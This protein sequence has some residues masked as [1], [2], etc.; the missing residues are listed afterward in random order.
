M[1]PVHVRVTH[2]SNV[3]ARLLFHSYEV[4]TVCIS[5]KQKACV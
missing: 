2:N 1:T 5:N 4:Y 3:Q